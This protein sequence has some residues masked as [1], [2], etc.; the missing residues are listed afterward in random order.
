MDPQERIKG[1]VLSWDCEKFYGIIA[2]EDLKE[3]LVLGDDIKM[4]RYGR[5][6]LSHSDRVIFSP[7]RRD[8]GKC[9][10]V[11]VWPVNRPLCEPYSLNWREEVILEHWSGTHGFAKRECGSRIYINQD[12]LTTIGQETLKPGSR[13][14]CGVQP[15]TDGKGSWVGFDVQILMDECVEL[16][17]STEPDTALSLALADAGLV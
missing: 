13:L 2:D 12:A 16:E 4:D 9:R 11:N 5:Q 6:F 7:V 17:P 3:Y 14:W 10:A 15:P 8:N 1:I